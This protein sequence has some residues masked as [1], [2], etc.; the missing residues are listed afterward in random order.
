M[1][2]D[3]T[4]FAP[5]NGTPNRQRM[6]RARTPHARV[7]RAETG[8]SVRSAK[9]AWRHHATA[10]PRKFDARFPEVPARPRATMHSVTGERRLR[11]PLG[12]AIR[13]AG[14]PSLAATAAPSMSDA[15]SID[16]SMAEIGKRHRR[17]CCQ[18]LGD[19]DVVCATLS[20]AYSQAD[21]P[22]C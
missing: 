1:P 13:S 21:G 22:S 11:H 16:Q 18:N 7:P 3:G 14:T 8:R 4:G 17:P 12:M 9:P 15:Q 20:I 5:A 19:N 10:R 2:D 6:P